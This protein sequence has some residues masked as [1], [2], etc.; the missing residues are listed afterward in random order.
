MIISFLHCSLLFGRIPAL[1]FVKPLCGDD[2]T[3]EGLESR[4]APALLFVKPLCGDD[5][6]LEGLESRV[7]PLLLNLVDNNDF[8]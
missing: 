1:L 5:P 7:A 8:Y 6:T 4:V 3:L 2:P